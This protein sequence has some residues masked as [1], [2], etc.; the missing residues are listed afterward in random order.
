MKKKF[1][2]VIL[3]STFVLGTTQVA[4]AGGNKKVRKEKC[5]ALVM[6]TCKNKLRL[7]ILSG[8]DLS[9]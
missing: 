5:K 4:N 7:P 2:A 8:N 6:V 9:L 3:A 1:A